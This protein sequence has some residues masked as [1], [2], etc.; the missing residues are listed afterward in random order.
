MKAIR[1]HSFGP[2]EVMKLET[3]PELEIGSGQVLVKIKAAG[4]NPVDAYIQSGM[5]RPDLPLPYTPG[6]D[7]AGTIQAIGPGVKKFHAGQRVYLTWSV[8]GSYAEA[9]LCAEA[10]VFSLPEKTSFAQG[11]AIGVPYGTAFRALFQRAHAMPGESVFIHGASGGVGLAAVQ[12]A[13]A[14]GLRVIGSAG[15]KTAVELVR[16]QGAHVVVSHG[17]PGYLDAVMK[18][19]EGQ[20]VDVILE[21]LANVNLGKDLT[22]LRKGGRVVVI[23]SRGKVEIDPRE[24]MGRDA[25]ILGMSLFNIS[26]AELA[27]AHAAIGAGLVR[28]TL[29]PVVSREMPLS[30][31]VAAHHAIM[32]SSSLG[33]IVLVP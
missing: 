15:S 27:S 31:A 13:V 9:A 7:G 1:I 6:I 18:S 33:K 12:I 26:P 8:S 4:V 14:A 25:A 22:L 10:H 28:G 3:I 17:D 23:G 16:R 2:P 19:T 29:N 21:M 5:Y 30:D 20:G 24:T 11:A 32:E